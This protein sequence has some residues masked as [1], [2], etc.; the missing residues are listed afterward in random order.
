MTEIL[1]KKKIML[2]KDHV[3]LNI[4]ETKSNPSMTE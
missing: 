3:G 1:G 4:K 2:E